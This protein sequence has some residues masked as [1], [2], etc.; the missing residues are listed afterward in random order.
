MKV[1]NYLRTVLTHSSK[2]A[3]ELA[4]NDSKYLG[5]AHKMIS[6]KNTAARC[7]MQQTELKHEKVMFLQASIHK[8]EFFLKNLNFIQSAKNHG[9]SHDLLCYRNQLPRLQLKTTNSNTHPYFLPGNSL[10]EKIC[11]T[12][13]R[14]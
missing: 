2:A 8:Y 1:I 7:D 11:I 13:S 9:S 5:L 6:V 3:Y 10:P 4:L 12:D 14:N